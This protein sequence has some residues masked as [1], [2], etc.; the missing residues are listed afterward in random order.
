MLR[1]LCEARARA[2][3]AHGN[4][5]IQLPEIADVFIFFFGTPMDCVCIGI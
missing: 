1:M 4:T 5:V 3:L 2:A